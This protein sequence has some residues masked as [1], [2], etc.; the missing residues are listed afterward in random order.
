M[1]YQHTTL[2]LLLVTRS[3]E[4]VYFSATSQNDA[5][6]LWRTDGT[7]AERVTNLSPW[8]HDRAGGAVS[9]L[10]RS[11]LATRGMSS[12]YHFSRPLD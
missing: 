3:G 7:K 11:T 12:S 2:I 9:V 8:M 4:H 1:A 5:S 10:A 6:D